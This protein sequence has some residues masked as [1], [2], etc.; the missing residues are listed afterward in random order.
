VFASDPRTGLWAEWLKTGFGEFTSVA[1][2]WT[3]GVEISNTPR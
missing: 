3:P 1:G 2:L